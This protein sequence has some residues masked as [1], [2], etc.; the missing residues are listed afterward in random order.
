MLKNKIK[1]S[2]YF[3]FSEAVLKNLDKHLEFSLITQK[4]DDFGK[5]KFGFIDFEDKAYFV[6]D[7]TFAQ[8]FLDTYKMLSFF[9]NKKNQHSEA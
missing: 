6:A 2:E 8:K 5:Q 7:N 9:T 1:S 3:L 4:V